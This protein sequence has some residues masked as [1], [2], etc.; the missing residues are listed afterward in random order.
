MR[1]KKTTIE[2]RLLKIE[3]KRWNRVF[4]EAEDGGVY[5][6]IAK[7]LKPLAS[8]IGSLDSAPSLPG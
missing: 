4:F 3:M 6:V 1:G 2:V 7:L 5:T 8:P